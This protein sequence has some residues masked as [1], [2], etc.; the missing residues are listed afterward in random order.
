[1]L[2]SI[3]RKSV[4]GQ[5][6]K[7]DRPTNGVT[8]GIEL[9]NKAIDGCGDTFT[10]QEKP[11]KQF[12]W[13][14]KNANGTTSFLHHVLGKKII[15]EYSIVRYP[16]INGDLYYYH[17]KRGIYEQDPSG[18]AIKGII[19]HYEETLKNNQINEV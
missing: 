1:M 2:E 15:E 10:L 5:R 7:F 6:E 8:Y 13:F 3:F 19:R 18:K 17:K 16:N 9:L 12:E 11:Q 14:M 4:L